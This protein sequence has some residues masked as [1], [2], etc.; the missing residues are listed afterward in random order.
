[1]RIL[2]VSSRFPWPAWRGNQLRTVQWLD[3]LAEHD[4]LLVCPPSA[5]D[6]DPGTH[7]VAIR[8]LPATAG[9]AVLGVASAILRGRPAQEG[10]YD[11][12]AARRVVAGAV[13]DWRPD[14]AVI[15]M[16]RCAWAFDVIRE[17][18]PELPLLFDAIDS[19]TLHYDR[20]AASGGILL[21]SA[22]HFEAGRCRR[23]EG[24]LVRHAVVT[25]AVSGRDLEALGAGSRGMVVPVTGGS[26]AKDGIRSDGEMTVLLSG[27]LGY[28]PTVR[29]ALWFADR[30]WPTLHDAVPSARWV[31]AGAR[32]AAALRRLASRPGIEV[33]GD[34]D[35]LG[36][37]LDRATVAIAPMASGSGVPIK[38]LEA[39]AAGVPV[40]V[41][42]WSADGLEDPSAVAVADGQAAWASVLERLLG[43]P[44]AAAAQAAAGTEAWLA[45]YRPGRVRERIAQAVGV[46]LSRVG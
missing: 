16:V 44:A 27:N 5:D 20:A 33:H 40:V 13:R 2:L 18:N 43:D 3:A 7:Q 6:A 21:R 38:I 37:F 36:P 34:V 15:Q 30:V 42:P 46:A 11:S 4:C 45:D 41:D 8:H 22:S 17:V 32:P 24:E 23:R 12:A 14:L 28:R 31:L 1:M 25:T 19:M 9:R 10:F 26:E 39:M 35:D 29:G